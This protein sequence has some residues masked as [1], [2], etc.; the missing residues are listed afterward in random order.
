MLQL[1]LNILVDVVHQGFTTNNV[2]RFD[3]E[4]RGFGVAAV[5]IV[6]N[7]QQQSYPNQ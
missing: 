3:G 2:A 6:G 7:P 1:K 5:V 4:V